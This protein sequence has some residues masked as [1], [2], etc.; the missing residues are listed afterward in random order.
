LKVKK[1]LKMKIC[2]KHSWAEMGIVSEKWNRT[3]RGLKKRD[4]RNVSGCS[5]CPVIKIGRKIYYPLLISKN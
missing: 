4:T 3:I 2:K 1:G 5:N